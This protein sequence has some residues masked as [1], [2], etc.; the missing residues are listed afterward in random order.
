MRYI[1]ISSLTTFIITLVMMFS[2]DISKTN[3]SSSPYYEYE[4]TCP[5]GEKTV[6]RCQVGTGDCKLGDQEFCDEDSDPGEG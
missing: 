5:G 4:H 1:I 3:A 2:I 6:K